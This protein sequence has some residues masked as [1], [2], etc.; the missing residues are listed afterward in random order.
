M[1]TLWKTFTC[2]EKIAACPGLFNPHLILVTLWALHELCFIESS[3]DRALS[4]LSI[5]GTAILRESLLEETPKLV[6]HALS[7]DE[8]L[9]HLLQTL[10]ISF[11]LCLISIGNSL[12]LCLHLR[13]QIRFVE[14]NAHIR[15]CLD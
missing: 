12:H 8:Y 5:G 2:N 15:I 11:L 4:L 14:L 9:P 6:R 7:P 13:S 1:F 10:S 3:E